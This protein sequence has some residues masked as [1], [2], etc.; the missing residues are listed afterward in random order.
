M[1]ILP[2][3][4]ATN[5]KPNEYKKSTK[6][7]KKKNHFPCCPFKMD[8]LPSKFLYHIL[9]NQMHYINIAKHKCMHY[10]SIIVF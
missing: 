4:E 7:K 8:F 9:F 2:T 6:W 5:F 3:L 10:L 1:H